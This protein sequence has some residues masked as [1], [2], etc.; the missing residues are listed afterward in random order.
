MH[1]IMSLNYEQISHI[2]TNISL[3]LQVGYILHEIAHALGLF[4]EQQRP[5]RDD[6]VNINVGNIRNSALS[7]F[8][9]MVPDYITTLGVPYDLG[10]I[11]HYHSTVSI[12]FIPDKIFFIGCTRNSYFG[13]TPIKPPTKI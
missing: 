13:Q 4:H 7:N 6:E 2:F 8:N 3:I 5:D 10:S 9:K 1:G 12:A 11:M